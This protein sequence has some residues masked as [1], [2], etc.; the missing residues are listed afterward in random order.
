MFAGRG[1]SRCGQCRCGTAAVFA[2]LL[3]DAERGVKLNLN[4]YFQFGM[5][6]EMGMTD[7]FS[8]TTKVPTVKSYGSEHH[9]GRD[10]GM[11][12]APDR[13]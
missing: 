4:G 12:R 9:S 3:N 10:R 5:S 7:N 8:G 13:A 6:P 1:S 11:L 2:E